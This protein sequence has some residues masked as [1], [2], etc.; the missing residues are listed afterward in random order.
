MSAQQISLTSPHLFSTSRANIHAD[1]SSFYTAL[2]ET[3]VTQSRELPDFQVSLHTGQQWQMSVT[4]KDSTFAIIP[5]ETKWKGGECVLEN[6]AHSFIS[7]SEYN[8]FGE[9]IFHFITSPTQL[10]TWQLLGKV[11]GAPLEQ[12]RS[13]CLVKALLDIPRSTWQKS[14]VPGACLSCFIDSAVTVP[15]L[16]PK[17]GQDGRKMSP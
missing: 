13:E 16:E 4:P 2:N 17:T 3:S 1:L 10:K 14:S 12:G 6:A 5:S 9:T 7:L 15:Y 8:E 11:L